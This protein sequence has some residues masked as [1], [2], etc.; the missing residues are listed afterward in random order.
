MEEA[1]TTNKAYV[2]QHEINGSNQVVGVSLSTATSKVTFDLYLSLLET[3]WREQDEGKI[4]KD[5]TFNRFSEP[6]QEYV[7]SAEI[8]RGDETH[9]IH[10]KEF[11]V[12]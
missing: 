10:V 11:E 1:T 8:K 5:N 9:F 6:T 4:S 12:D 7:Y 2:T 3:N